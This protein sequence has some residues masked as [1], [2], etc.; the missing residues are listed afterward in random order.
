MTARCQHFSPRLPIYS[1]QMETLPTRLLRGVA[2]LSF[3]LDA[4]FSYVDAVFL[5]LFP[6]S[7]GSESFFVDY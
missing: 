1:F 5:G 6:D 2:Y 3:N 7:S 4:F